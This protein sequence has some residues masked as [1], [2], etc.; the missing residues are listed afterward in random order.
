MHIDYNLIVSLMENGA[1]VLDLGCGNGELLH[2][3]KKEKMVHGVGIE[4]NSSNIVKCV[5]KGISVIQADIDEGLADFS[6]NSYD[7]VVLNQTLQVIY[8]PDYVI[9]EMLRVGKYSIVGF[10]NFGNI[11]IRFQFLFSGMMPVTKRLPYKW[12]N[13]P[14]IHLLTVKDFKEFCKEKKIEIISE[15]YTKVGSMMNLKLFP[16]LRAVNA[17][18]VLSRD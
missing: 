9:D 7:Y 14:N 3:L 6:D 17:F 5:K 13:T 11:N 1:S 4:I 2:M 15:Y 16:N 12:Y 18:F 10:P 8:K